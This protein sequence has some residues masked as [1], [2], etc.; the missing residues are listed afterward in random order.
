LKGKREKG[1]EEAP[2]AFPSLFYRK[3]EERKEK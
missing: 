3:K 1:M 2:P